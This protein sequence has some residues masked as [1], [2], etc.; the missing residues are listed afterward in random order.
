MGLNVSAGDENEE[1]TDP[2]GRNGKRSD[3]AGMS[4]LGRKKT[5][6]P[7]L[8]VAGR[9][10]VERKREISQH[11]KGKNREKFSAYFS[12]EEKCSTPKLRNTV[13]E[14]FYH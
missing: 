6:S 3:L 12:E 13:D 11:K 14:E 8:G 2:E 4:L 9:S 1:R 7:L 10:A 5:K